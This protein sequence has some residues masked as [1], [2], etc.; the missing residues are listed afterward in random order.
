MGPTFTPR[1]LARVPPTLFFI[2]IHTLVMYMTLLPIRI[3]TCVSARYA[4][5]K[6]KAAR[7]GM[8]GLCSCRFVCRGF[9]YCGLDGIGAKFSFEGLLTLYEVRTIVRFMCNAAAISI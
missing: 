8:D 9:V 5:F 2:R 1:S 7:I 3:H 6:Y 4:F